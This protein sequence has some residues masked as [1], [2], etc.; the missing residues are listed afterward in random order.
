MVSEVILC[1]HCNTEKDRNEFAEY[2][3]KKCIYW[4]K[5]C[6]S[7][8]QRNYRNSVLY[9]SLENTTY[10]DFMECRCCNSVKPIEEFNKHMR[11]YSFL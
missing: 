11:K 3:L 10:N 8:Y 1:K 7:E 9:P 4:C 2:N 5:D 6:Y